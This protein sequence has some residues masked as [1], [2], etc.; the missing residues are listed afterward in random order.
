MEPSYWFF[1]MY[2]KPKYMGIEIIMALINSGKLKVISFLDNPVF[3]TIINQRI[4]AMA[5]INP[6]SDAFLI[7]K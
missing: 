2:C 6:N 3:T 1:F 5:D 4:Y 7:I